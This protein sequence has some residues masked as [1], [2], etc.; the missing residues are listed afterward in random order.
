MNKYLN[1]II[2]PSL[3]TEKDLKQIYVYPHTKNK[4]KKKVIKL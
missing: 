3:E 4:K 1:L 2:D